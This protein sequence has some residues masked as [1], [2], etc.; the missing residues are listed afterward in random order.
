MRFLKKLAIIADKKEEAKL[1]HQ[2]N[3]NVVN[4]LKKPKELPLI[5]RE[6]ILR[7]MR[8]EQELKRKPQTLEEKGLIHALEKAWQ[9][10]SSKF[11]IERHNG[12]HK[13]DAIIQ[14]TGY[15]PVSYFGLKPQ[16]SP[17]HLKDDIE[18]LSF[19]DRGEPNTDDAV[20]YML[21]ITKSAPYTVF[22]DAEISDM[23]EV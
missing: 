1:R 14:M 4:R 20:W 17:K 12:L 8:E 21:G 9:D 3:K 2:R 7:E 22:I 15:T 18:D 5:S 13:D 23:D 6:D 11:H 10:L 19:D 16:I